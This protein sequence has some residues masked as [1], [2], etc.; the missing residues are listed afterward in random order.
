MKWLEKFEI[1]DLD[2]TVIPSELY[3]N[4]L[5]PKEQKNFEKSYRELRIKMITAGLFNASISFYIYKII[6]NLVLL[7]IA[8]ACAMYSESIIVHVVGALFLGLFWQQC[9][10]LAHDFLHHQVFKNR[11]YG[12]LMGIL[13]GR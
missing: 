3:A 5:I 11:A 9:G 1:G 8:S 10:W 7:F 4:K 2:E 6:S 13:V 12:D